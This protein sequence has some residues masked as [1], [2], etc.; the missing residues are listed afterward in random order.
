MRIKKE[1]ARSKK[2][3]YNKEANSGFNIKGIINKLFDLNK[4]QIN[5]YLNI[6]YH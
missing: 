4:K 5:F 3:Y 2:A 1:A 6:G